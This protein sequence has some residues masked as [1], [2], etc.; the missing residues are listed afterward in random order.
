[1][2]TKK[3]NKDLPIERARKADEN[4]VTLSSGNVFADLGFPD[5]EEL[6]IKTRL[7]V[8]VKRL[9]EKKGWTQ[10]E[11]ALH[12][13]TSQPKISELWNGK[14]SSITLDKLAEWYVALGKNVK[15]VVSDPARNEQP[16][17][18]AAVA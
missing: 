8:G 18:E 9:I 3:R 10:S 14:L 4:S 7:I 15:F 12:L 2:T 11:A 16:H 17:L 6:M 13:G 5:A 1:M